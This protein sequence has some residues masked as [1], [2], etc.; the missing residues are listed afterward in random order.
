MEYENYALIKKS[1]L[2]DIGDAIREKTKGSKLIDPANFASKIRNISGGVSSDATFEGGFAVKFHDT[3]GQVIA[4]YTELA[5]RQIPATSSCCPVSWRD[6]DDSIKE[7]PMTATDSGDFIEVFASNYSYNILNCNSLS[8]KTSC[9][10]T[11][12]AHKDS[13]GY[14]RYIETTGSNGETYNDA[15]IDIGT[16]SLEA[17]IEYVFTGCPTGGHSVSGSNSN[18][19]ALQ[20]YTTGGSFARTDSGDGSTFTP[21]AN[22]EV[23]CRIC[24]ARQTANVN[25]LKWYPMI[26]R[27]DTGENIYLPYVDD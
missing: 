15:W 14:L 1:T 5:G 9:G 21:S 10:V 11:V 2:T 18:A 26:R 3:D 17:G 12:K 13:G 24:I 6:I 22:V 8:T 25:G 19:Y 4:I 27:S 23:V 20:I 16:V 7:F